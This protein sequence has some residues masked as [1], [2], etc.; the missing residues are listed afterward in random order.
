MTATQEQ[1]QT[2]PDIK[3]QPQYNVVLI[4]DQDHSYDYVVE[5]LGKLFGHEYAV[6]YEMAVTL[7]ND[8]RVVVETTSFERAE[9][10]RDQIQSYGV[11]IRLPWSK[12]SMRSVIEQDGPQ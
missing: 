12:N 10:K 5:M 3:P 8:G 6:A 7:D 9:L 11:D 1:K 4:D 2:A